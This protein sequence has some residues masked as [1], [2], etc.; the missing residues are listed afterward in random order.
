MSLH[1]VMLMVSMDEDAVSPVIG[2][3]MT[4]GGSGPVV[5]TGKFTDGTEVLLLDKTL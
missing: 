3:K 1:E 5:V 2:V 4:V